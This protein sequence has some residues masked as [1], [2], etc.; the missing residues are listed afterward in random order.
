[1][2]ITKEIVK[3]KMAINGKFSVFNQYDNYS[4]FVNGT[5]AGFVLHH[6]GEF[7]GNIAPLDRPETKEVPLAFI[8]KVRFK[9]YDIPELIEVLNNRK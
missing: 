8:L 1:M 6:N 9:K 7:Y 5:N 2:L 3:E 4:I